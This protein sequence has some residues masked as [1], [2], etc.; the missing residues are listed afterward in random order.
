MKSVCK[1]TPIRSRRILT[2]KRGAKWGY[3]KQHL[4]EYEVTTPPGT[5]AWPNSAPN[6]IVMHGAL[7]QRRNFRTVARTV[8]AESKVNTVLLD[9]RNHGESFHSDEMTLD[10]MSQ[11]VANFVQH[12]RLKNTSLLGHSL[13]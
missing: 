12:F 6:L 5:S 7:G 10:V 11:D 9:L 8:S 2:C 4:L 1:N 13:V 3:D